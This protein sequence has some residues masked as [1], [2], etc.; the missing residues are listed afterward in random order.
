MAAATPAA[1]TTAT[2]PVNTLSAD[3]KS[4]YTAMLKEHLQNDLPRLLAIVEQE[5][6]AA[7]G[8]WAHSAAGGFLVVQEQRFAQQCRE[9]QRLCENGE[10]WTT[11]LDERAISLHEAICDYFGLDE[12][13]TH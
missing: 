4:R 2:D 11:E 3:D 9:L 7:L 10:P 5:D 13:S 12:A 6:R 1:T 8:G